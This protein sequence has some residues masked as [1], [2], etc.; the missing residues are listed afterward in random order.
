MNESILNFEKVS[1]MD[2]YQRL[3]IIKSIKIPSNVYDYLSYRL[4]NL[5]IEVRK[6][7]CQ[8]IMKLMK[9]NLLEGWCWQTTESAIPFFEDD[10]CICRGNLK[11]DYE[12][13]Y[14]HSWIEFELDGE[15]YVFDPCIRIITLKEVYHKIFEIEVSG[16]VTSKQVS[17]DIVRRAVELKK[18]IPY[19]D[20]LIEYLSGSLIIKD[21]IQIYISGDDDVTSPMYRNSTKYDICMKNYKIESIFAHYNFY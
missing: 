12:A 19:K 7:C 17:E 3:G 21:S 20:R 16:M 5:L 15:K 11:L 6:G 1:L 13:Y 2:V 4:R 10:D 9:N 8:N 14:W 18:I